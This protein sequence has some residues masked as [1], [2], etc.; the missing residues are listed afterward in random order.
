MCVYMYMYVHLHGG[1]PVSREDYAGVCGEE[2]RGR[3]TGGPAASADPGE[4]A[5]RKEVKKDGSD[6]WAAGNRIFGTGFQ[7]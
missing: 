2:T 4:A 5:K 6:D 3:G 1:I 7:K